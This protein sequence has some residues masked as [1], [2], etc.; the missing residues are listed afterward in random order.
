MDQRLNLHKPD[1]Q[2]GTETGSV[3]NFI[4]RTVEEV[5]TSSA[6]LDGE[7]T[8]SCRGSGAIICYYDQAWNDLKETKDAICISLQY[9][10]IAIMEW[11]RRTNNPD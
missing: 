2:I 9:Y 5:I 8:I 4:P 3:V 10:M 11:E 1:T 7:L 6:E